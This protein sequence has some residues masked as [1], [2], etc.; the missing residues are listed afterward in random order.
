MKIM[1]VDDNI[2]DMEILFKLLNAQGYEV[3]CASNGVEALEKIRKSKPDLV[4][5]DIMMPQMD[6]FGLCRELKRNIETIKIPVIIYS[7]SFT[8]AQDEKLVLE[9]GAV[10]Y[11]RKPLETAIFLEKIKDIIKEYRAGK[12]AQPMP[13]I[14]DEKEYLSLYS[15][16]LMKKLEDKVIELE[17]SNKKLEVALDELKTIDRL[18]DNI[19]ANVTHEL[20][21]PLTHALGY[22]ELAMSETDETKKKE[23]SRR[24]R[25]A[26]LRENEVI[27]HLIEAAYAEK[28]L[29]GHVKERINMGNMT[30]ETIQT[31]LPNA[32]ARSIQVSC[33]V[34]D[35]LYAKGDTNQ[36]KHVLE[37]L[38]DNA[39]KFNVKGGKVDILAKSEEG[40]V[41]VCVTDT[42][43]G[44]PEDKI[45]KLFEKMY[46]VDSETTRKFGGIGL[47]LS[48]AK[49][50]IEAHGG[51]IWAISKPG[52]GSKFCF[53]IPAQEDS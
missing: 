9:E 5:S 32:W 15:Q 43:I 8:D 26:L 44:I 14:L 29:L 17:N 20:R 13:G 45:S 1:V 30:N 38:L 52:E 10:A 37:N 36:I 12:I 24:C 42:G 4:I 33:E 6:G 7:S 41:K 28:G 49:Y 16:R 40:M 2:N 51:R 18:K 53:T 39:I 34:E 23:F 11:F 21:T 27:A 31:L 47:G 35:K 25:D 46:Q 3:T 22:V 50:I 48:I 19:L